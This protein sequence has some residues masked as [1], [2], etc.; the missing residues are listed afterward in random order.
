M[1]GKKTN[2]RNEKDKRRREEREGLRKK[3]VNKNV[4]L[5]EMTRKRLEISEAKRNYWL[6]YREGE[7]LI[8]PG[9]KKKETQSSDKNKTLQ[10][11]LQNK[12]T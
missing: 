1:M 11:H 9:T 6:C 4:E 7:R 2:R 10:E 12:K 3:N 5:Q 8:K